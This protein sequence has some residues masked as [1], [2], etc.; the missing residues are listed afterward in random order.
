MFDIGFWELAMI[1]V[2]ALLVIG[3]ERLPKVARVGGFWL[4]KAR[5]YVSTVKQELDKELQIEEAKQAVLKDNPLEGVSQLSK[6]FN[7]EVKKAS[8]VVKEATEEL[9]A[10]DKSK[11]DGSVTKT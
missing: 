3:P 7:S 1:G 9:R 8:D 5:G 10:L 2:V 11:E 6:E 4:G